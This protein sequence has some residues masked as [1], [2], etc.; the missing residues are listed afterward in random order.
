M[1]KGRII[2]KVY[3]KYVD[4]NRAVL[5]KNREISLHADVVENWLDD[6]VEAIKFID[7]KKKKSW[8]IPLEIARENWI[9]KKEGQEKQ[10]YFSIDLMEEKDLEGNRENG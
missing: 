7:L 9:K 2:N 10:Y 5:W 4:F 1:N 6:G 3:Q 8:E